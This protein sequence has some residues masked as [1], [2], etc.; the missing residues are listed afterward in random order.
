[1][2]STWMRLNTWPGLTIRRAVPRRELRERVAAGAVDAGEAEDL[3]GLAG[4]AR[5]ARA[6]PPRL[7][8]ARASGRSPARAA[9]SSSTQRAA[10][11]A[12]DADRRQVADP[13]EPRRGRDRRREMRAAPGRRSRPAGSRRGRRRRRQGRSRSRVRA[14]AVEASR[15][16]M[17]SAR[18]AAALSGEPSYRACD[19]CVDARAPRCSRR[20]KAMRR[21]SRARRRTGLM[22]PPRRARRRTADARAA[23]PFARARPGSCLLPAPRAPPRARRRVLRRGSS[24]ADRPDRHGAHERRGVVEEPHGLG[25]ERR[26]RPNCRWRSATLRTKRSR[27]VRLIGVPAKRARKAASS[28]RARSA[29]GRRREVLALHEPRLAAGL[30]ELVPGADREAVVAAEDAVAD[31]LRAAPPGCAPCARSSGTRCSAAHR[32]GR[33]PERRSSGR[34]RGSAGRSRNGRARARRP[35]AP[36]S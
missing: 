22:R 36:R 31:A 35:A 9:S 12:I 29:S 7:R 15:R 20:T 32:A 8:A 24:R 11:V 3:D 14:R 16:S 4:R 17:P 26:D 6:R 27:P 25:G 1:M 2:S 18:S 13:G 30:R 21:S 10:V 5:R 33:A 23:C 34:R 19:R 28:R